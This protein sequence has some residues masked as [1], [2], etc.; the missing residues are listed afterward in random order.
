MVFLFCSFFAVFYHGF[1]DSCTQSGQ[2]KIPMQN[3]R[4]AFLHFYFFTLLLLYYLIMDLHFSTK[5]IPSQQSRIRHRHRHRYGFG[6][7]LAFVHMRRPK[8]E[9]AQ[10][11]FYPRLTIF[12]KTEKLNL[13]V[14]IQIRHPN[15]EQI[16]I[17][18]QHAQLLNKPRK[19][20]VRS[21]R[22]VHYP[23]CYFLYLTS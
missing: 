12:I 13:T 16:L 2:S 10:D 6:R 15:H 14:S 18:D 1:M 3:L 8:V 21:S 7:T 5:R 17:S 19:D 11:F 4:R 22:F 9:Q 20:V 23:P